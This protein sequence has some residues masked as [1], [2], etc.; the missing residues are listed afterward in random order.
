MRGLRRSAEPHDR[1][2][3]RGS[4]V[5]RRECGRRGPPVAKL[6]RASSGSCL[7]SSADYDSQ[8]DVTCL[9]RVRPPSVCDGLE[10]G[11]DEA[12][13]LAGDGDRD[14]GPRLAPLQESKET[15]MEP[16]HG[17]IGNG[18]HAG[19]LALASGGRAADA[20]AMPVVPSGFD[21][22]AAD[23]TITGLGDGPPLFPAAGGV[24][25][26]QAEAA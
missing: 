11:P 8:M 7:P 22:K 5:L 1:S 13:Q 6:R 9:A 20:G 12:D 26:P 14:L 23:M 18:D 16:G 25:K 2:P 10:S 24:A 19:G 21:E 17:S 3:S 4:A 15:S